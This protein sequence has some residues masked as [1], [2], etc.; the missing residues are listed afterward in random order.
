MDT[1]LDWERKGKER[2]DGYGILMN[3]ELVLCT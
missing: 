3:N 2:E 1:S